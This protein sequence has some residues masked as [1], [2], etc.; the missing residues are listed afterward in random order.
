MAKYLAWDFLDS[1][2][3]LKF[4]LV[5]EIDMEQTCKALR[6]LVGNRRVVV[7]GFYGSMPGGE[8]KTLTRG[9]SDITGAIATAAIDADVYEN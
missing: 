5:E 2:Q 7:P 8:I 6:D 9:G 1:A 4:N 3:W